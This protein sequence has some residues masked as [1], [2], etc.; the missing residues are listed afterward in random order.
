MAL[1]KYENPRVK[2]A[3]KTIT[4]ISSIFVL[5]TCVALATFGILY[6]CGVYD[7]T[8]DGPRS[9]WVKFSDPET[10]QVYFSE[11]FTRG[12][13]LK[14]TFKPSKEG[15]KFRGWD[16]NND[17]FV[18]IIPSHVYKNIDAKALWLPESINH[19]IS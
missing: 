11:T 14:Y 8:N 15:Y 7:L 9:Y 4:V 19:E 16:L 18:D 17:S 12:D 2:K 3:W 5:V 1:G 10:K 13:K 6:L